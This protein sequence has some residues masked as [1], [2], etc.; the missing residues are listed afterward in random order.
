MNTRKLSSYS[1]VGFNSE[2]VCCVQVLASFAKGKVEIPETPIPTETSE[3]NSSFSILK[4]SVNIAQEED[5][6]DN[7]GK[8]SL[9]FSKQKTKTMR[10]PKMGE[11]PKKGRGRKRWKRG[12]VLNGWETKTVREAQ[13]CEKAKN[14]RGPTLRG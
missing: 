2:A 14:E 7:L 10:G 1:A 12:L 3:A 4:G 8:N 9:N 11:K 13:K 5:R 6:S